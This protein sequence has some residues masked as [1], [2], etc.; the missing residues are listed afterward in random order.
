MFVGA[1]PSHDRPFFRPDVSQLGRATYERSAL[2]PVADAS[3]GLLLL[4]S[5]L[6]S[7]R[8]ARERWP[9]PGVR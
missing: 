7:R 4:L 2:S 9:V 5:P 8:I 1:T 6:L 3:R